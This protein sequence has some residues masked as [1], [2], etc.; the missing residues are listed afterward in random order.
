VASPLKKEDRLLPAASGVCASRTRRDESLNV[1]SRLNNG[2]PLLN[3][4]FWFG[5]CLAGH[6]IGESTYSFFPT[7]TRVRFDLLFGD[8][9]A[10]AVNA[11]ERTN[12][13]VGG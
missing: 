1:G 6:G 2:Y 9:Q 5:I 3:Q 11:L 13:P 4:K 8:H 7:L 10:Y 12:C